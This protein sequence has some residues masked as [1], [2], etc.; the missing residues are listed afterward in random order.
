MGVQISFSANQKYQMSPRSYYLHYY[1]RLRPAI[2]GS[3]LVFGGAIDQGLNALLEKK[4]N[5]EEHF[6][7][8]WSSQEINGELLDLSKTDKIK[9]SKSD[10]DFT[11]LTDEDKGLI[12]AGATKEWVSLRRKGLMIIDAYREQVIPQIKE[13]VAVQKYVELKNET[14]DS[15]IGWIDFIATFDD[16]KTYI[17][18]NKTTSI[19]YKPD[20]VA[21][22][23]QLATYFEAAKEQNIKVDGAAYI[24]IPK[25]IR[26]AKLPLIPIDVIKGEINEEILDKT[27]EEYDKTIHG[28]KMGEFACTGC[29]ENVFGCVYRK[30]CDSGGLDTDGLIYV[31]KTE[32][33]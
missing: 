19:K 24:A 22:S 29:K 18:D 1:L 20:S 28:I 4:E 31:D 23:G 7:K 13:V 15:L 10:F 3:A 16:G 5:P 30:F 33:K 17:V 2:T 26:K 11:I 12:G 6:I 25:N 27:F 9:Y 32:R 8:A 14:G 21:Q